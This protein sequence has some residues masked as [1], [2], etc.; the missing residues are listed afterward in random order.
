MMSLPAVCLL[1]NGAVVIL[2]GLLLGF[3]LRWAIVKKQGDMNAWRVAHSVL[4]MDGLLML[5]MGLTIPYLL[6]GRLA[7]WVLVLSLVAAGYGFLLAF[8]VGAWKGIRGLT[9][10]PFG[11]NTILFGAHVLGAFGSLVGI[12]IAIFGYLKAVRNFF[13]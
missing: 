5:V 2:A 11:L 6:L 8:T 9:A 4:V 1:L 12:G 3:P 13:P 10:R 7:I